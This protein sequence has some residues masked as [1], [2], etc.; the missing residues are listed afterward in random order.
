MT[1]KMTAALLT[2]MGF[3]FIT[4]YIRSA[5]GDVV[6]TDYM[7]IINTYL[8]DV[9]DIS[10]YLH[11]DVL[12]RIP[13]TFLERLFNVKVLGYSTTFDM[14]LGALGLAICAALIGRY[15]VKQ[16]VRLYVIAVVMF[17]IFSL[18]KW[19]M[20]TNGT[21][22]MHFWAIALFYAHFMVYDRMRSGESASGGG[23]CGNGAESAG[24]GKSG[25]EHLLLIL[26]SLIIFL[27]AGP[28]CAAYSGCVCL[29]YFIDCIC[30][31]RKMRHILDES[32]AR[33]TSGTDAGL[34][35]TYAGHTDADHAD[36]GSRTRT[37]V[38]YVISLWLPRFISV[39][40]PFGLYFL[41]HM[42][43]EY[44]Y[45]GATSM[46]LA[47]LMASDPG[48]LP[49]LFIRSFAGLVMTSET[50]QA[51]GISDVV[52]L[53]EG[54]AII[55]AYVVAI[56]VNVRS[57]LYKKTVVPMMLMIMA[58][59]SHGLIVASRWIFLDPVYS[60]SSRYALQYMGGSIGILLTLFCAC[61]MRGG[62]SAEARGAGMVSESA[63]GTGKAVAAKAGHHVSA[64]PAFT[65]GVCVLILSG[66]LM[67]CARE[68][69]MAPYRREAFENMRE[70][71]VNYKDR[72]DDELKRVLQYSDPAKTRKALGILEENGWNV[73]RGMEQSSDKS[74]S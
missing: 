38:G 73:F 21:G 9:T 65:L 47:Q 66:Q 46:S 8:P 5:T 62:V 1:K 71:A 14:L 45:S 30:G 3:L 60:M 61:E 37:Y 18:D 43:L 69:H 36:A 74:G 70:T 7:R 16:N 67:N 12:E 22:W 51:A 24:A 57:G 11:A 50:A 4:A 39:L 40:I 28:Y 32:A 44:E 31:M 58:L 13:V 6:Y 26:P 10:P 53:C 54:I 72:T 48:F 42:S 52:V 34:Q 15:C 23:R 41:S 59:L 63:E 2:V 68:I 49:G 64:L 55:T 33:Q 29:I 17:I 27:I 20:L 35:H 56:A 19:E 25:R